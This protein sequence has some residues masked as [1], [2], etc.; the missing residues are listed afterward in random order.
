M[1]RPRME[2][3][4]SQLET[5]FGVKVALGNASFMPTNVTF[6]FDMTIKSQNG[7]VETK[8]QTYFKQYAN[9]YGLDPSDLGKQFS[10][11]GYQYTITGLN[12]R[13]KRMPILATRSGGQSFKFT[14]FAVKEGL[15]KGGI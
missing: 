5:E 12:P 11:Q 13:A 10:S 1:I 6:K 15:S 9:I 7:E 3:I 4:L 14:A 2:Q 8:E